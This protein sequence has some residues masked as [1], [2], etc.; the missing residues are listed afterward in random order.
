MTCVVTVSYA[1]L[2]NGQLDSVIK[3]TRDIHQGDPIS[4]YLYLI[5]AKG[6]S[7]LLNDAERSFKIIGIKVARGSP[8][9]NHL[10]FA[11]DDIVFCR[12][13]TEKWLVV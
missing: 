3:P 2:V 8:T 11:Y 6:L 9:V 1:V 13:N 5:C 10:L 7:L 12:A 4:P